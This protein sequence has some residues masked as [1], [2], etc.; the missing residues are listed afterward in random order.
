MTDHAFGGVGGIGCIALFDVNV[1][2]ATDVGDMECEVLCRAE[3]GRK[4]AQYRRD[5]Q[6]QQELSGLNTVEQTIP[7]HLITP[8]FECG[9]PF[10]SLTQV[11]GFRKRRGPVLCRESD[12]KPRR[13]LSA[14]GV[15]Q[16]QIRCCLLR[17]LSRQADPIQSD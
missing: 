1:L 12:G 11:A 7:T 6:L 3:C 16:L 10:E 8:D 13:R 15:V 14:S 2:A 9:R 5:A 4:G 17:A